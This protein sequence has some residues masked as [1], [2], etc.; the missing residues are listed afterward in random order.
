M[1]RY[2]LDREAVVFEDFLRDLSLDQA[3]DPDEVEAILN[4]QPG[5]EY[6]IGGGAVAEFVVRREA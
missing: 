3:L 1:P 2:T 4:L 5:E 6:R